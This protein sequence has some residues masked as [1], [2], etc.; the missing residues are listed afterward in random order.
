M[1]DGSKIQTQK[2]GSLDL[3]HIHTSYILLQ[4]VKLPKNISNCK[5]ILYLIGV[6]LIVVI[7]VMLVLFEEYFI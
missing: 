5:T 6:Y 3:R 7:E 2:S 4:F 1:S